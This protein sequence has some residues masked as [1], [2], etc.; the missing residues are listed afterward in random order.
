MTEVRKNSWTEADVQAL[1]GQSENIRREFKA[2]IMYDQQK[3]EGWV[4]KLSI[5]VS[6][7]A[8]TEGGDIFWGIKEDGKAT[9]RVAQAIDGVLVAPLVVEESSLGENPL[10]Y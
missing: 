6:A 10:D 2:G 7:L 9:P 4:K 1:I 5:E 3:E 8:N